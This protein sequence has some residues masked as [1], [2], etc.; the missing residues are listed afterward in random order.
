MDRRIKVVDL[1]S[2]TESIVWSDFAASS[3]GKRLK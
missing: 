2:A 3:N 1:L